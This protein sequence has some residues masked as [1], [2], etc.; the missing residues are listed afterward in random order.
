MYRV[1]TSVI[2]PTNLTNLTR[3]TMVKIN[4]NVIEF[5]FSQHL[6]RFSSGSYWSV[7]LKHHVLDSWLLV[8]NLILFFSVVLVLLALVLGDLV[9]GLVG[10]DA[11]DE[12]LLGLVEVAGEE[13]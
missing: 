11:G 2:L 3:V 13:D 5:D 7:G 1:Y 4:N 8:L 10:L 6:F 9:V 12:F